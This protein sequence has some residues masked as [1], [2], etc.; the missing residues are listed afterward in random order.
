M[1][2]SLGFTET[3]KLYHPTNS[4]VRSTLTDSA[5]WDSHSYLSYDGHGTISQLGSFR[6]NFI[7]RADA[8]VLSNTQYPV[9]TALTCAAGEYALPGVRS[10]AASMVLNPNGG[11]IAAMAPT[12][13][14]LDQDA[15]FMGYIYA[16]TLLG[17]SKSTIGEAVQRAKL[18]SKGEVNDFMTRI[19][20]VVG[21]PAVKAR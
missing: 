8:E 4:A 17:S 16:G 14:S 1:L 15:Q 6:E 7:T 3:T 12:G 19:Y 13:L 10:V 11:A 5:T 21:D 20:S 18:L 9:F 2:G